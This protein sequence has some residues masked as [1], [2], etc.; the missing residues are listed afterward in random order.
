MIG[1]FEQMQLPFIFE[2]CVLWVPFFG[3]RRHQQI[4]VCNGT[5]R[6]ISCHV[7][8]LA[9]LEPTSD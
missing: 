8:V 5:V 4:P 6:R 9:S 7:P 1:C 3:I 2:F